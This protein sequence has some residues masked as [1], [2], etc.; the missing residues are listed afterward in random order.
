MNKTI[1]LLLLTWALYATFHSYQ[2]KQLLKDKPQEILTINTKKPEHNDCSAPSSVASNAAVSSTATENFSSLQNESITPVASPETKTDNMES[3]RISARL[4]AIEKFVQLNDAQREQLKQKFKAEINK[5]EAPSLEQVIGKE[6]ADFYKQQVQKA[7][8]KSNQEQVDREVFY[9]SRILSLSPE[10]EAQVRQV[11]SDV[12]GSTDYV[13]HQSDSSNPIS[14]LQKMLD[15]AKVQN[16]LLIEKM[17]QALTA[18]QYQAFIEYQNNSSDSDFT[19]L[20][21]DPS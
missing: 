17:K 7:Y 11:V 10:Q 14:N 9:L 19:M 4:S 20:H 1:N 21:T 13:S 8:E 12:K 3:Y 5:Q 15:S 6:S 16:D 2:L 18:T